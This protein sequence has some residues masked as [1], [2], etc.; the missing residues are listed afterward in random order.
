MKYPIKEIMKIFD[1]HE[2]CGDE[3]IEL[4]AIAAIDKATTSD[5]TFLGNKK[6]EHPVSSP[7]AGA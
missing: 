3:S 5:L 7:N 2:V 1:N 6:N 4:S